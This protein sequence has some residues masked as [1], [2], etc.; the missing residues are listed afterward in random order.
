MK[1]EVV[2]PRV[3]S[4]VPPGVPRDSVHGPLCPG[5]LCCE[6]YSRASLGTIVAVISDEET[7]VLWSTESTRLERAIGNLAR[8][9]SDEEDNE[10]LRILE[11]AG[12]S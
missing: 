12:E 2:N 1:L 6:Y 11:E 4:L 7:L 8:Q 9:I 3:V 10:I 5:D